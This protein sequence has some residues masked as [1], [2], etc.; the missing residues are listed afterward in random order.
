MPPLLHSKQN[1]LRLTLV[2]YL[3]ILSVCG[4]AQTKDT[5][6]NISLD[7]RVEMTNAVHQVDS[8]K[9]AEGIAKYFAI[10]YSVAMQN[11]EQKL[12]IAD[13]ST[14]RFIR[15]FEFAFVKYFL[16]ASQQYKDGNLPATSAWSCYFSQANIHP[17][18]FILMGVNAHINGEMWQAMVAACPKRDIDEHRKQYRTFESAIA[19]V[20]TPVFDSILTKNGYIRLVNS[21]TNGLA[22]IFGERVLS[23]WRTRSV[24]LA[25]LYYTNRAKFKRR[26]AAVNRKKQKVDRLIL[27]M[28]A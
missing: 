13:T 4:V 8:I 10:V 5:W 15:K 6:G 3:L 14:K 11:V 27:R 1:L 24:N 17:L 28:R 22:R 23:K 18:K 16:S 12:E 19:K 7:E 25:I 21:M 9:R 2:F 20:Y 26:L